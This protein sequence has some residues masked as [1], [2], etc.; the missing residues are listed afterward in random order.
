[1][2]HERIVPLT[3]VGAGQRAKLV[4]IEAGHQ[5][6]HRLSELG[7]TPGI[8]LEVF[9]RNGRGPLMLLVRDTRLAVGRGIADR[10]MVELVED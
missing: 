1:M 3:E 5:A 7:L 6:V 10:V 9:H 8:E 4:R 2:S